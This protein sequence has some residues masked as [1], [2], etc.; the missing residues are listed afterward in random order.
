MSG[1]MCNAVHL[2]GTTHITD[3]IH[4]LKFRISPAAFFQINTPCAETLYQCAIDFGAPTDKTTVLDICCGTGTIGLCFAKHSKQIL[5]V[6]IIPEAIADAEFNA[7]ENNIENCKFVAGSAEDLISSLMRQANV[8][9]GEEVL[10]IVDPPRAGLRKFF[11]NNVFFLKIKSNQFKFSDNKSVLQL[12]NSKHLNRLVYMSCSPDKAMKNWFD[13]ARPCS[14]TMRGMPF[15]PKMAIAVDMF[16]HTHHVEL[17]ILFER[18]VFVD[19]EEEEVVKKET[20]KEE[21]VK[22]ENVEEEVVKKDT[23]EEEEVK[24]VEE[25]MEVDDAIK[26][27]KKVIEDMEQKS[28]E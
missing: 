16:P 25:I 14:K 18:E 1:Q 26:D 10:A 11:L 3:S 12:R 27:V 24:K 9:E 22:K 15:L 20:V 17:I 4:G 19:D 21:A 6:E 23:V 8:G 2:N 13:L 7:K 5:G 28:T